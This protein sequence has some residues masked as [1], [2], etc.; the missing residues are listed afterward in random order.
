L[1]SA[2]HGGEWS[3]PRPGRALPYEKCPRYPLD[4]RLDGLQSGLDTDAT[5][6]IFASAPGSN[7]VRPV[8]GQTLYRLSYFSSAIHYSV[9]IAGQSIYH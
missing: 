9:C 5:K 8:C 3:A 6:N 4:W 1:T 2:L 7:T